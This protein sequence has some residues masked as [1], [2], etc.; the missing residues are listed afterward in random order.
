MGD[1][2]F[3]QCKFFSPDGKAN[4]GPWYMQEPLY[5]RWKQWDCQSD[6][7]YECMMTREEERKRDGEKPTKYFGNWPLKHVYGIQVTSSLHTLSFKRNKLSTCF[8]VMFLICIFRNLS[9]LLS[10]LLTLQY[11]SMD[12]SLTSSS[13]TITCLSSQTGKLTT[14]ITDYCI[15]MQSL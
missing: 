9:P 3:H 4:D 8:E 6:C 15:S 12:G 10:L 5:L 2:C 11:S 1:T 14:S 7:Q 13:F